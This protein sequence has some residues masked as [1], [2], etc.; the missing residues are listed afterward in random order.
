MLLPNFITSSSVDLQLGLGFGDELRV[1]KIAFVKESPVSKSDW[2]SLKA[3]MSL[4]VGA[5][6]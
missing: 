6:C 5:T 1:A 3:S 2:H 4:W